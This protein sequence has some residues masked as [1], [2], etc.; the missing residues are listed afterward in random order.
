MEMLF[1][2]LNLFFPPNCPENMKIA[3]QKIHSVVKLT[4]Q[5]LKKADQHFSSHTW[6]RIYL[7]NF[8]NPMFV[9]DVKGHMISTL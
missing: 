6:V 3:N 4:A 1:L 5:M 8:K 7:A 9:V 2:F